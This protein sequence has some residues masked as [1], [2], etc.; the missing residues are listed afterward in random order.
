MKHRCVAILGALSLFLTVNPHAGLAP[1]NVLVVINKHSWA[2]MTVANTFIQLRQIPP[3]NVVY[4]DLSGLYSYE[5]CDV[6][7]FPEH[8]LQSVFKEITDRGLEKQIFCIAYSP[9][10]PYKINV[11]PDMKTKF[12]KTT[13]P[14]AAITG[15]TVTCEAVLGKNGLGEDKRAAVYLS[16]FRL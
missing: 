7:A 4:L 16:M 8:I 6:N 9:D 5:D 12:S 10:I 2:S 14:L 13:T 15:L 3:S 11:K 1:E